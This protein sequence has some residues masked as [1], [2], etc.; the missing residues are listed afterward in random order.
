MGFRSSTDRVALLAIESTYGTAP[1]MVAADA[2]LLMGSTI[3][4]AADKLERDL[5]SPHFGG[6][7]FVLVGK[8]VTLKGDCDVLGAATP[9][10]AAPLGKLYRVTGHAETLTPATNS[11][12]AP[13]STGFESAAV[14]FYWAGVRFR[15]TGVRGTIDFDFSIKSYAKGSVT[16]TGI[17]TMPTDAEA[18]SGISWTA[19]QTP[20][21]IE[22]P[23]WTV[24]VGATNVH[25][26]QLTL[27]QG[28]D[29]KLIETSESRQVII[30][31]RKPS[32]SLKV[33][34][35]DALA[36]WNPWALAEAQGIVTITNTIVSA[37]G[38]NVS[39]PIRAQLEYPKPIDIEGVAGFEI[40]FAAIPS[41]AGGDE[42]SITYT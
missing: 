8:R 39:M 21:A 33:I 41:G 4:T 7:P 11:V 26:Q 13:I 35:N 29:V 18:P 30:T 42:Y 15:M 10:T 16:L 31:D 3:E 37:A 6:N 36:T 34:K 1:A 25:A 5:D 32:G 19:F 22:T 17:L 27:G 28:A 12:Y 38:L 40:P 2:I 20:A 23:T 24:A 14:D 9:G